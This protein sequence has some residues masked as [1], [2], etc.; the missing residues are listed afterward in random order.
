MPINQYELFS[1]NSFSLLPLALNSYIRFGSSTDLN[2]ASN[3]SRDMSSKNLHI[4]VL[5]FLFANNT[6]M[7]YWYIYSWHCLKFI[8]ML[9]C[10][11]NFQIHVRALR[12]YPIIHIKSHSH[13]IHANFSSS[14]QFNR[15]YLLFIFLCFFNVL[16][17]FLVVYFFICW[18]SVVI[19]IIIIIKK[20]KSILGCSCWSVFFFLFV[21]LFRV[22]PE[23]FV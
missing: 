5:L 21:F 17:I 7:F 23:V 22:T 1:I 9:W 6:S 15:K 18:R 4:L 3:F 8:C 2:C 10:R 20:K 14:E 19:V 12:T 11:I 13:M 16:R